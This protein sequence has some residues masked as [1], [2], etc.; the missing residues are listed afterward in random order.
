MDVAAGAAALTTR[1]RWVMSERSS[2]VGYP[3]IAK[4]RARRLIGRFADVIVANSRDGSAYWL[5]YPCRHIVIPNAVPFDEIDRT[6]PADDFDADVPLIVFA[7]R[8]DEEKNLGVVIDALREVVSRTNATALL[9]GQGPL[10]AFARSRI[11][12]TG[13]VD[14]IRLTGFTDRLWSLFKRAD[15]LVSVSRFEGQPNVVLEAA[16][17]DTPLVVSDIPAHREFLDQS[18]AHIVPPDDP[19]TVA[20]AIVDCLNDKTRARDRAMRARSAVELLS[21][22]AISARYG[23]MYDSLAGT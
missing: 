20:A 1:R 13:Y 19:A 18:M 9:C 22:A 4:N 8:L 10:E 2:A 14:R 17:C 23:E 15:A 16:A 7:G 12:A 3:P 5:G 11:D 21:V 6:L